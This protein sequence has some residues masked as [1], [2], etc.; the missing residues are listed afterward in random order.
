MQFKQ[1]LPHAIVL[2]HPWTWN[3]VVCVFGT[4]CAV[5]VCFAFLAQRHARVC[6]VDNVHTHSTKLHIRIAQVLHCFV[7]TVESTLNHGYDDDFA[8][9]A[10]SS[11]VFSILNHEECEE[12]PACEKAK[13]PIST[14]KTEDLILV[15]NPFLFIPIL[16]FN[17]CGKIL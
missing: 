7:R 3:I 1:I 2:Q 12:L 14:N 17:N 13:I 11:L 8:G 15:K 5:L 16:Y 6:P 9:N 10:F 4:T